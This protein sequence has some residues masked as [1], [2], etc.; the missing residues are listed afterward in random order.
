MTPERVVGQGKQSGRD[1][2]EGQ[3]KSATDARGVGTR[4]QNSNE[5]ERLGGRV[6]RVGEGGSG[7]TRYQGDDKE[8]H[9]VGDPTAG[10]AVAS[11]REARPRV[12]QVARRVAATRE[13]CNGNAVYQEHGGLVRERRWA[14]KPEETPRPRRA[15]ITVLQ[16]PPQCLWERTMTLT[17][18][19]MHTYCWGERDGARDERW[20]RQQQTFHG[21]GTPAA[22]ATKRIA[23]QTRLSRVPTPTPVVAYIPS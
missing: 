4:N 22:R 5:G 19:F 1:A 15:A 8:G 23:V 10:G 11:G 2:T 3:W 6:C 13:N 16:T 18:S 20:G 9:H 17:T 14:M 12:V 7:Q 21:N